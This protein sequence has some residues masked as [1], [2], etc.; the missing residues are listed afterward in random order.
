MMQTLRTPQECREQV[1]LWRQNGES[2]VLVPTMGNL[3]AG[4][5]SLVS[6]A[7]KLANRL[8]VSIFVNPTQ[9]GPNEDFQQYPRT[10]EDDKKKLLA[11]GVDGLFIPEVEQIYG[12]QQASTWV[13][14]VGL[15]KDLCGANRPNH[16]R[17]VAT[18]VNKLFNIVQAD[19]A[20]FGRKDLQQ[21]KIIEQMVQDLFLDIK[22]HSIATVR[23]EDGLA[24]SSRNQFLNPKQ[25][26]QAS[27]I[28]KVLKQACAALD[29]G[30]APDK[31]EAESSRALQLEN[32]SVDYVAVRRAQDLR[33][34]GP[35]DKDFVVL[36]AARLGNTRLIDNLS[37]DE[38]RALL[39]LAQAET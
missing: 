23:D 1:N 25:R 15:S 10:L 16:F 28:Y 18:V 14:V 4:H 34:P 33:A 6:A 39:S 27:Y 3:H 12:T 17:G 2:I 5:L 21:V 35:N 29:K 26:K 36:I 22:I 31:V 20:V 9:F 13:D 11:L 19:I 30:M 32:F 7:K 37:M 8:I 24:L 38:A